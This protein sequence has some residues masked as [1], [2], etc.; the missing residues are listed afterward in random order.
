MKPP[1]IMVLV[2]VGT[3]LKPKEFF[4]AGWHSA[5]G[6]MHLGFGQAHSIQS[7]THLSD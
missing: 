6:A 3:A 1:K 5:L 2:L 4:D 7:N